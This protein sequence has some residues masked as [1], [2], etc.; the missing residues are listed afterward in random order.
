MEETLV[1]SDA[2]QRFQ[3]LLDCLV[4]KKDG[5]SERSVFRGLL[6]TWFFPL[7]EVRFPSADFCPVLRSA[8]ASF[9][10]A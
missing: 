10:A 2:F 7:V 5:I 1:F 9:P 6:V 4:S 3:I 8:K